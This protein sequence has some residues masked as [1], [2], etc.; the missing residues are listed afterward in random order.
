MVYAIRK[1][2]TSAEEYH[3]ISIPQPTTDHD[4]V[5]LSEL[6]HMFTVG[7]PPRPSLLAT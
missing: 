2:V 5:L 6:H 3:Q 4:E 1:S 7:L